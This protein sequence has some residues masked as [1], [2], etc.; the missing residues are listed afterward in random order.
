MEHTDIAQDIADLK[1]AI[2]AKVYKAENLADCRILLD[3]LANKLK[4]R[5][6]EYI[7]AHLLL[8]AEAS[9]HLQSVY[10]VL[11]DPCRSIISSPRF[12]N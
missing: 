10:T 4:A 7:D 6:D 2:L 3:M 11:H 8:P 9:R 1:C 12:N 5:L